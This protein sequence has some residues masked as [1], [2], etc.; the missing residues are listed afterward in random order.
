AAGGNQI[1][2]CGVVLDTWEVPSLATGLDPHGRRGLIDSMEETLHQRREAF[3]DPENVP[4]PVRV[5]SSVPA[6]LLAEA[7]ERRADVLVIASSCRAALGRVSF[8]SISDQ[9]VHHAWIPLSVPPYEC[10]W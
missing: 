5:G 4:T 10:C 6:E 1:V 3:T 9:F 7:E 2:W 8:G